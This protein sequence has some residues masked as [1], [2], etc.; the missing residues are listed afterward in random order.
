[1]DEYAELSWKFIEHLAHNTSLSEDEFTK[2]WAV[3]V[4]RTFDLNDESFYQI[5]TKFD[6]FQTEWKTR[7]TWKYASSI[8]VS[9]TPTF[10][11]NGVKLDSAPY[12]MDGWKQFFED[13]IKDHEKER[14]DFNKKFL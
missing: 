6:Q 10:F 7:E 9:G 3:E 14:K 1:M 11:V 12:T 5:Y 4:G 8:G 13:L 2:F